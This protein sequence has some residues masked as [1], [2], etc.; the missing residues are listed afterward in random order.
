MVPRAVHK[1]IK[2]EA[3]AKGISMSA[4]SNLVLAGDIIISK[5]KDMRKEESRWEV[6]PDVCQKCGHEL[7]DG[8]CPNAD[9]DYNQN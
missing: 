9:C 4:Y 1:K 5:N 3:D 6:Y 7:R 8:K 2:K